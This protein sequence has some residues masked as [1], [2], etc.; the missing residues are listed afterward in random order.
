MPSTPNF[1]MGTDGEVFYIGKA[2]SLRDR[3]R[4]YFSGSDTRA[5][6]V[7]L[8]QG[9]AEAELLARLKR[10]FAKLR[11]VKPP[12]SRADSAELYLVATGF[13][14]GAKPAEHPAD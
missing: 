8:L 3:L 4:S 12:S 2:A 7:K 6:V 13:R 5:F 9:G 11:H 1:R 14:G 10:A